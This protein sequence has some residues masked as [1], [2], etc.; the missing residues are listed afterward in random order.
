MPAGLQ[1]PISTV[2]Q[3]GKEDRMAAASCRIEAGQVWIPNEADWLPVL[4]NELLAFPAGKHDDQVN[5]ISQFLLWAQDRSR[6]Q[7][8]GMF[9]GELFVGE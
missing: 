7:V 8:I 4:L 9:G 1:R 2:P 5:S 3:G 6:K